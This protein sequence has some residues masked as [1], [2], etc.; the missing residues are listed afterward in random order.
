M[1]HHVKCLWMEGLARSEDTLW[2]GPWWNLV[3][4]L[5]DL[6]DAITAVRSLVVEG[7]TLRAG[8]HDCSTA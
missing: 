8:V 3:A 1:Y 4:G 6:L 5:G 7:G 2:L